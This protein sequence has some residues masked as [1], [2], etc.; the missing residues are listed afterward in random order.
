MDSSREMIRVIDEKIIA[1]GA[2]NMKR[3]FSDLENSDYNESRFDFIFAQMALHH[4]ADI[5][6]ILRK[7]HELLNPGSYLAIADLYPADGSFHG[8]ELTGHKGFNL[9][10]LAHT[11]HKTG[12]SDI[13][14]KECFVIDR[15]ITNDLTKQYRVFLI[16]ANRK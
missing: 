2:S 16:I 8:K 11:I 4:V 7:F 6:N 9:N 12:F 15:K 13:S 1:A 5:D 14:H 3:V 10:E